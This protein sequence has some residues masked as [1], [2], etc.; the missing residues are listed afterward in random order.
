M[1]LVGRIYAHA[2]SELHAAKVGH[3]FPASLRSALSTF[4]GSGVAIML[5]DALCFE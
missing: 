3:G 1:L 4:C 5:A 2:V